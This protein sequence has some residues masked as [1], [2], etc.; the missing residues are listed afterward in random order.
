MT[1]KGS[2]RVSLND[3]YMAYFGGCLLKWDFVMR[4][5]TG[6]FEVVHHRDR[7]GRRRDGARARRWAIRDPQ[8]SMIA[9][10][11]LRWL[12]FGGGRVVVTV[13]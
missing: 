7:H 5:H 10:D 3:R 4:L 2:G 12:R 11:A 1:G 6:Q 8:R 13:I 9:H